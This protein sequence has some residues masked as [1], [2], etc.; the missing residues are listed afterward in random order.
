M[1]SGLSSL[2]FFVVLIC[3]FFVFPNG[4]VRLRELAVRYVLVVT[5]LQQLQQL[6]QQRCGER[7][8]IGNTLGDFTF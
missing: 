1:S 8:C 2:T 3:V 6:Q 5:L 7:S 4:F